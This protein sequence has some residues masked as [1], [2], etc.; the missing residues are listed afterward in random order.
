MY[1]FDLIDQ[2][3]TNYGLTQQFWPK[4]QNFDLKNQNLA[5]FRHKK[6]KFWLISTEKSKILQKLTSKKKSAPVIALS[7]LYCIRIEKT[8]RNIKAEYR[9]TYPRRCRTK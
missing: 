4:N 6:P 7:G 8:T 5:K 1:N 9:S 2:L 3:L